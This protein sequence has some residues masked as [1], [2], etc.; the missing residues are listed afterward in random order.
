MS[1]RD[2]IAIG[3]STG[4]IDAL[5]Q[6]CRQL[7]ADLPAAIFVTVHVGAEGRNLLSDIFNGIGPLPSRT[8]VDGETVEPGRVYVASADHHLLV[9]DG[10]VRLG[11]GPR[12]NLSRP[13]VDPLF[14]S[15]AVTYGPRAIGLVLTGKLNDGAAGL[16]DINRCGGVTI[17]QNPSDALAPDMPLGALR[18]TDVDYRAPLGDLGDLLIRLV[19]EA[20]GPV[21]PIPRAIELEVDIALGRP[22]L[23]QTISQIADPA[24]L[25][26]PA[27]G[28]VLSQIRDA[29]PSRFRCQVGHAYTA[30]ALAEEQEGAVDEAIRIALRIIEERAVLTE[31]MALDAQVAG[32]SRM[33]AELRKKAEEFDY[34]ADLLRN[35]A[36]RAVPQQQP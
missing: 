3:G 17:V 34:Y 10:V 5:K 30:E 4:A 7:P 31:R 26:C 15:I 13:A 32:R 16:R 20:P 29:P 21:L 33:E 9:I 28:G 1:H 25:S 18:A 36:L 6:L 35:A 27:C 12:E 14:R 11:R 2:V 19:A 24:T 23:T 8:A 22:C